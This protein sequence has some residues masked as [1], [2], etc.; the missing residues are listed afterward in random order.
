MLQPE[1]RQVSAVATAPPG[2]LTLTAS[3]RCRA[4]KLLLLDAA[5][6]CSPARPCTPSTELWADKLNVYLA[7]TSVKM[8]G[9]KHDVARKATCIFPP[10]L[11]QLSCF[12]T[13]RG[14]LQLR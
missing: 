9:T 12:A 14:E 2:Q 4:G 3:A 8:L 10:G 1:I 7:A 5:I 11:C 13:E 6:K